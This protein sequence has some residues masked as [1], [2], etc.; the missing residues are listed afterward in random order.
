MDTERL[1]GLARL[2]EQIID[3]VAVSAFFLFPPIYLCE[4]AEV[5]RG[6]PCNGLSEGHPSTGRLCTTRQATSVCSSPS[7]MP[8]RGRDSAPIDPQ[9]R[10]GRR[11]VAPHFARG[12]GGLRQFGEEPVPPGRVGLAPLAVPDWRACVRAQTY[13]GRLHELPPPHLPVHVGSTGPR[14]R[15]AGPGQESTQLPP[16]TEGRAITRYASPASSASKGIDGSSSV[17]VVPSAGERV[18]CR[19]KL[20]I[21]LQH[22]RHQIAHPKQPEFAEEEPHDRNLGNKDP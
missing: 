3:R 11:M 15:P 4:L 12:G 10:A 14:P 6:R 13:V 8:L 17:N 2:E 5:R 19:S 21:P 7:A 9:G 1:A 20:R 18:H 22:I 16:K